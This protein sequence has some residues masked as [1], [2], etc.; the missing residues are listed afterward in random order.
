MVT[1]DVEI[2]WHQ[3]RPVIEDL[4]AAFVSRPVNQ[5]N[6]RVLELNEKP[7]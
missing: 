5:C 3:A 4:D 7:L 6:I 2:I 1:L